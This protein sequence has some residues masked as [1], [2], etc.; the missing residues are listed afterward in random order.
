MV[1]WF[2]LLTF[3]NSCGTHLFN[4][5]LLRS[6]WRYKQLVSSL[7]LNLYASFKHVALEF[8]STSCWVF[9][10]LMIFGLLVCASWVKLR[11]IEENFISVLFDHLR[12]HFRMW[13]RFSHRHWWLTAGSMTS[14][15]SRNKHLRFFFKFHSFPFSIIGN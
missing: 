10:F 4:F 12:F 5:H 15:Y 14:L 11:S 8:F 6:W 9:S 13:C 1:R 7:T 3:V 2:N